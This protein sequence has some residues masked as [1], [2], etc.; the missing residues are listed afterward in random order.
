[1]SARYPIGSSYLAD[2]D[3]YTSQRDPECP[4]R[5]WDTWTLLSSYSPLSTV[6][7]DPAV[8]DAPPTGPWIQDHGRSLSDSVLSGQN[9]SRLVGACESL[10]VAFSDVASVPKRSHFSNL[11]MCKNRTLHL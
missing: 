1:M 4:G 9:L 10:L 7:Y 11:A 2:P 6:A 8:P 5:I 3:N